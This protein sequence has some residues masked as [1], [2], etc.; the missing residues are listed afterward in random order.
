M[1]ICLDLSKHCIETELRR[2]H[3]RAISAYFKAGQDEKRQSENIIELAGLALETLDFS[4][5]RSQYPA[6]AGGTDQRVALSKDDE[7]L[8]IAIEGKKIDETL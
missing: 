4:H 3:E 7:K 5:L 6:L 8:A 1:E 2:Q